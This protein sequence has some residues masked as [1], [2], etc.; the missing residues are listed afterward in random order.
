MAWTAPR[1]W[2]SGEVVTAA[3]MNVHVRDN[4]LHVYGMITGTIS[5]QVKIVG[6]NGA[7]GTVTVP[8]IILDDADT[9]L[10]APV[11]ANIAIAANGVE[12]QR[13]FDTGT[14]FSRIMTGAV[15]GTVAVFNRTGTDGQI[16]AFQQDGTV[17]G[18]ITVTGVTV[19][20]NTFQ[21]AH[22]TQLKAGQDEPPP[23]GVVVAT[24]E[25]VAGENVW[26]EESVERPVIEM[27][28]GQ[29]VI[30]GLGR[31]VV[32]H[33]RRVKTAGKLV[34]RRGPVKDYL[35][36]VGPAAR[37]GDPAVYG[38]WLG[39]VADDAAGRSF[40]MNDRPVYNVGAVGLGQ[41][42]VTDTA[43]DI[44]VGDLL[45]TST[46]P[47]EAQRQRSE[48]VTRST[49][50]KALAP[51]PWESVPVDPVLGYRW[52]LVPVALMAG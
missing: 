23:F 9:G 6:A 26:W 22:Y 19:A 41:A 25:L 4:L 30:V 42:R 52:T 49:L 38:V 48:V 27:V 12:V 46:R 50:G 34:Q 18:D 10:F 14:N 1:T 3:I 20:Y 45:E 11:A 5:Q 13:W 36:H 21:G 16:V 47:F 32:R 44:A 39:K 37:A 17:E 43:G 24:G 40:G 7:G 29:A 15:A 28:G 51:V 2:V 35:P 8:A 31:E 33:N